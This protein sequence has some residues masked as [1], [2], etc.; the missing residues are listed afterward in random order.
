MQSQEEEPKGGA[1]SLLA[2]LGGM[3]AG[4]LCGLIAPAGMGLFRSVSDPWS[5]LCFGFLGLLVGWVAAA[6][7]DAVLQRAQ[8]V[9]TVEGVV[10]AVLVAGFAGLLASLPGAI[11]LREYIRGMGSIGHS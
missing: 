4:F 10:I 5:M 2:T 11:F 8:S 3:V 1:R 6:V 7:C 9:R